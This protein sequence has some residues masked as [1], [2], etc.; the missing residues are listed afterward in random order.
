MMRALPRVSLATMLLTMLTMLL[1][2][3]AFGVGSSGPARAARAGVAAGASGS[4]CGARVAVLGADMSAG[5]RFEVQRALKV[6]THTV[7]ENE[8]YQ[9]ELAQAGGFIP[10]ALLG[11]KRVAVSSVLLGPLPAGSGLSVDVNH[12]IQLDTPQSYA[13]ALL[14]AG[15]TDAEVRVAAPT[16]QPALGTTA[17]LGLLRAAQLS[18]LAITPQRRALAIREAVLSDQLA[19]NLDRGSARYYGAVPS[20]IN[21]LKG[22]AASQHLTAPAALDALVTRDAAAKGIPLNATQRQD[23]VGYLSQLVGSGVYAGIAARSPQFAP[24]APSGLHVALAGAAPRPRATSVPATALA[25]QGGATH[26]GT[27]R[28]V[29]VGKGLVT[30]HETGGDHLYKMSPASQLSVI[31]NGQT[32]SLGALQAN[33]KITLTTVNGLVTA[34]DATGQSTNPVGGGVKNVATAVTRPVATAV[35]TATKAVGGLGAAGIAVLAAALLLLLLLLPLLI[36]LLRRRRERKVV[37][38]TTTAMTE[39]MPVTRLDTE[40][41]V[42]AVTYAPR[43]VVRRA[44]GK[45]RRRR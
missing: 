27:V 5:G 16:S 10:P 13:N 23:L 22:S 41:D 3:G 40:S 15:V 44:D 38:T 45:N 14:T 25:G 18:C 33:D 39:Q 29:D 6:G 1:V 42:N 43:R 11:V 30:V 34:I 28:T 21:S 9:D 12:N 19:L 2:T 4:A 37:T 8:T 26:T 31:R 36:G 35:S 24:M 17:L 7:Q 32:S 20:L